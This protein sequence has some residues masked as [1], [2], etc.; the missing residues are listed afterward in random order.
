[1]YRCTHCTYQPTGFFTADFHEFE[2]G[3]VVVPPK[4][5]DDDN[6]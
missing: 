2:T 3:H 4:E 6:A 1:M 5:T